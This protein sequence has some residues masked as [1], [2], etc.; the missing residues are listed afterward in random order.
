[1]ARIWEDFRQYGIC[2]PPPARRR[3]RRARR[4]SR[5]PASIGRHRTI[6]RTARP[7]VG[8]EK[9]QI[10][11]GCDIMTK[12]RVSSHA[13]GA[14]ICAATD[15]NPR[16]VKISRADIAGEIFKSPQVKKVTEGAAHAL[17]VDTLVS[18]D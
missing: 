6:A 14:A 8:S 11:W 1:M 10:K 15:Q 3:P 2:G 16:P 9:R 4:S 7:W 18:A 12:S 13:I 5:S 17:E